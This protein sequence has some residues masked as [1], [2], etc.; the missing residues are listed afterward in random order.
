M[1]RTANRSHTV[2][3]PNQESSG[4]GPQIQEQTEPMASSSRMH[5]R[6]KRTYSICILYSHDPLPTGFLRVQV[7]V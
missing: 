6:A 4:F 1:F 3:Q 7:V 5:F 2:N